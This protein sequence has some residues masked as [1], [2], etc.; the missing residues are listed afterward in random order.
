MATARL[1]VDMSEEELELTTGFTKDE[2]EA[3]DRIYDHGLTLGSPITEIAR[4]VPARLFWAANK[5][6]DG[7]RQWWNFHENDTPVGVQEGWD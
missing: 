2:R 6:A 5:L 7:Y 1:E 3:L 4:V